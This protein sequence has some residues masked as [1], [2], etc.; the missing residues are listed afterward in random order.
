MNVVL[1][2][3][4]AMLKHPIPILDRLISICTN[5]KGLPHDFYTTSYSWLLHTRNIVCKYLYNYSSSKII[6]LQIPMQ[7][8]NRHLRAIDKLYLRLARY[9]R[10]PYWHY[11]ALR[12]RLR[13]AP[14]IL[15]PSK[16]ILTQTWAVASQQHMQ[17]DDIYSK[18]LTLTLIRCHIP[19]KY[20]KNMLFYPKYTLKPRVWLAISQQPLRYTST[21]NLFYVH[22]IIYLKWTEIGFS[23]PRKFLCSA[24][25]S[26]DAHAYE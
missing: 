12:A 5:A 3:A 20:T 16:P 13:F 15:T 6:I 1:W 23:F 22:L 14:A 21:I 19:C 9:A 25:D 4:S 17:Y 8:C 2:L 10:S 11:A 24:E 7:Y 26:V 18:T